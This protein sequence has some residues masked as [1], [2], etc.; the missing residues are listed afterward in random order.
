MVGAVRI[1]DVDL[2]VTPKASFSSVL[3]MVGY[4]RDWGAVGSEFSGSESED[5][6]PAVAETLA[7][8][9]GAALK[10]GVLQGYV[11]RDDALAVV[12]GRI[13]SADQIARRPGLAVPLEVTYDEFE[14][15]IPENQILRT[16]LQRMST[17]PRLPDDLRHRLVHLYGRIEGATVITPGDRVPAW[18]KSRINARYHRALRL[19]EFVLARMGLGTQRGSEPVAS[20][21]INMATVFEQ[22][23]S[24]ALGAALRSLSRGETVAQYDAWLDMRRRVRMRP[25]VVHLVGG[26]PRIVMDAKYKLGYT[27]GGYPTADAYQLLAYC[28]SLSLDQGWLVYAGS[29]AEGAVPVT[30]RVA[31]TGIDIVQWPLDLSAAPGEILGQIDDLA[32]CA[33]RRLDALDAAARLGTRG[34]AAKGTE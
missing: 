6:W 5:L 34:S 7:R 24:E 19:A 4:S 29:K 11:T 10:H 22:F 2:V 8:L 25:D 33:Y 28:T 1:G 15:D 21:V 32:L 26:R 17:A 23:V 3:F 30:H 12:R 20:F 27:D 18:R 13:R 16:A 14:V 9:A 31:N